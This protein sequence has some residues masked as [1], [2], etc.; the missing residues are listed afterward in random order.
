[1]T[2]Y[3][4]LATCPQALAMR[5]LTQHSKYDEATSGTTFGGSSAL[6]M[7]TTPEVTRLR[8]R[9]GGLSQVMTGDGT[10]GG[11][12]VTPASGRTA[13]A[14]GVRTVLTYCSRGVTEA[15]CA[16]GGNC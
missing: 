16:G 7:T 14:E 15:T 8:P 5:C 9:A 2:T 10:G 13:Y 3:S 1:M 12:M 4:T 6:A 11:A